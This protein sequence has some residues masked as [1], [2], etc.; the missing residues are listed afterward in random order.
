[1]YLMGPLVD[2]PSYETLKA[3]V[4]K[5]RTSEKP[6]ADVLTLLDRKWQVGSFS[7]REERALGEGRQSAAMAE[8]RP[9]PPSTALLIEYFENVSKDHSQPSVRLRVRPYGNEWQL[10]TLDLDEEGSEMTEMSEISDCEE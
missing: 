4:N 3:H 7:P 2:F 10:H 6:I 8:P 5:A 1:M 9:P